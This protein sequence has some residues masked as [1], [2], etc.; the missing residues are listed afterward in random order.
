MPGACA[1]S[2][3]PPT[4]RSEPFPAIH[5]AAKKSQNN[6][7]RRCL[8]QFA[9]HALA[10]NWGPG[11][12]IQFTLFFFIRSYQNIDSIDM[13]FEN[14][15]IFVPSAVHTASV[16]KLSADRTHTLSNR[17]KAIGLRPT[18][19]KKR[20]ED[21]STHSGLP[22]KKHQDQFRT[23][24]ASILGYI[25]PPK[26]KVIIAET[27]RAKENE[28]KRGPSLGRFSRYM[29]TRPIRSP[30]RGRGL[31]SHHHV[32][33]RHFRPG[34]GL[35]YLLAEHRLLCYSLYNQSLYDLN[36]PG[37]LTQK[38]NQRSSLDCIPQ[39]L[40]RKKK[41]NSKSAS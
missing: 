3:I 34:G 17:S 16:Q 19:G 13:P 41:Y 12:L 2:R 30:P 20:K 25:V 4:R 33:A 26:K 38:P 5:V 1:H 8:F 21:P 29:Q 32:R 6:N 37:T 31:E 24:L 39:F 10:I 9:I 7:T 28:K 14:K 11:S 23:Q 27:D 15:P 22:Q 40:D 35:V 36:P 18:L